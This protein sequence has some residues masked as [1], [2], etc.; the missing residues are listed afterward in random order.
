MT[1]DLQQQVVSHLQ[2]GKFAMQPDESAPPDNFALLLAHVRY[3][4]DDC[5]LRDVLFSSKIGSKHEGRREIR[6]RK[7]VLR[8]QLLLGF[9]GKTYSG[10]SIEQDNCERRV[11]SFGLRCLVST[12]LHFHPKDDGVIGRMVNGSCKFIRC[13]ADDELTSRD[14]VVVDATMLRDPW[15]DNWS[16][17]FK[18][19]EWS[20]LP[21]DLFPKTIIRFDEQKCLDEQSDLYNICFG[22]A[23]G[24]PM[25]VLGQ[26]T[27]I[28]AS[29]VKIGAPNQRLTLTWHRS[30][31]TVALPWRLTPNMYILVHT[32]ER[33]IRGVAD[34]T[35]LLYTCCVGACSLSSVLH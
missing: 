25:L 20:G 27:E 12:G 21:P 35:H 32:P 3:P 34:V 11:S 4:E 29:D 19:T 6:S 8:E 18:Y 26:V 24:A 14:P 7:I 15:N 17:A 30:R 31:Q 2:G 5:H 22:G 28:L 9:R 16:E 1:S 13:Y 10:G 33:S 23:G